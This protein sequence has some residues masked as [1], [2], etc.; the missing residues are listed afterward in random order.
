[1]AD[2]TERDT[3]LT[4]HQRIHAVM[5]DT[6]HLEKDGEVKIGGGGYGY[7]SHDAVTA[8]I[9]PS[10]INNGVMVIPTVDDTKK[11][12]NRTELTV[13]TKFVNV[14]KPDDFIE[15][16]TIGYGVDTSDKG[17]GKALSYAVKY[18]Y[19]KVLMLNSADDIEA[20]DVEHDPADGRQSETSAAMESVKQAR[21]A[22][23]KSLK[24]AIDGASTLAELKDLKKANADTMEAF[25]DVT[26]DYFLDQ[27]KDREAAL[28]A[29]EESGS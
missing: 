14:D 4:I 10:F 15:V 27:F 3:K 5:M 29:Q 9:R 11:D 8:H 24:L 1:M 23:A 22:A 28:K 6:G 26:T 7:I 2:S 17:P 19:L 18:A 25:P 12:G 16:K 13:L 21:E 20:S